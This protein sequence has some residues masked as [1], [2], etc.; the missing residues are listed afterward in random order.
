MKRLILFLLLLFVVGCYPS[1]PTVVSPTDTPVATP[2]V[3][4]TL[5]NVNCT[6]GDQIPFVYHPARLTLMGSCVFAIGRVEALRV[7]AD[8]D[9]HMMVRLEP[10]YS[11]YVNQAN[12]THQSGDLVVEPICVSSPSQADAQAPCAGDPDPITVLPSVG[13]CVKVEGRWVSDQDHY[14]W[15]E[16][17]PLGK[18]S[19]SNQCSTTVRLLDT[20]HFEDP[21]GD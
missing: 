12:A 18:W 11:R 16:I 17:H 10:V 2:S 15:L 4:A 3:V 21:I 19:L 20:L 14:G 8:G 1:T 5:P 7:E 13:D 9:R 6:I